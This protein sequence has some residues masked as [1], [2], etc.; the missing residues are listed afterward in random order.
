MRLLAIVLTVAVITLA[1]IGLARPYVKDASYVMTAPDVGMV[2]FTFVN[3]TPFTRCIIGAELEKPH[4]ATAELHKTVVNG[5]VVAM[6]PVDKVCV[7]P[8][9]TASFRHLTYHLMIYGAVEGTIRVA[10]RLDDGAKIQFEAPPTTL[11]IH[12][13]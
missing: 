7:A 3:P 8:F 6:L 1:Y 2:Y 11:E 13:H 10:I 9:S 12:I 4:T 5:T